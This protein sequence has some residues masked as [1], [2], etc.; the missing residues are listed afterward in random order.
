[1][2]PPR[3]PK[4]NIVE[5]ESNGK[6]FGRPNP[7]LQQRTPDALYPPFDIPPPMQLNQQDQELV[8][9][10][11][12]LSDVSRFSA[13]YQPSEMWA[14]T[15]VMRYS[16]RYRRIE[17]RGPIIEPNARL[18][19]KE[20]L[21]K[22]L[23]GM[24]NAINKASAQIQKKRMMKGPMSSAAMERSIQNMLTAFEKRETISAKREPL[25][26]EFEDFVEDEISDDSDNDYGQNYEDDDEDG[27]NAFEDDNDA[28]TM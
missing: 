10:A 11:R 13:Y 3:R 9:K 7:V 15:S 12:Y 1:M 25:V 4:S 23:R 8:Q 14:S 22:R 18:M 27:V 16:D 26:E 24:N 20:L 2:P 6:K 17:G 19:P 21:G 28:S 5:T